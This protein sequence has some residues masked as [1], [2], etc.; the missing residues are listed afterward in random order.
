MANT[1][2]AGLDG[3]TQ[4]RQ[5]LL[6][7]PPR[8]VHGSVAL[9]GLLLLTALA[10]SALTEANLVVRLDG[11]VRPMGSGQVTYSPG[12]D[13]SQGSR[14]PGDGLVVSVP[15]RLGS[16]VR[17]GQV[18][19]QLETEGLDNELDKRRQLIEDGEEEVADLGR[20][21]ALTAQQHTD[22]RAHTAAELALAREEV[23]RTRAQQAEDVRIFKAELG[24]AEDEERRLYPVVRGGSGSMT[25]LVKAQAATA[26]ARA[27]I[28]RAAV[29]VAVGRVD[30]LLAKLEQLDSADAVTRKELGLKRRTRQREVES[31]RRD[32]VNLELQRR[33]T[34]LLAPCDGVVTNIDLGAG[35]VLERGKPV[36]EI[37]QEHGFRFE[38]TVS[39]EEMG[40]LRVGLP[41]R[42]KL[43]AFDH[44]RYGVVTGTVSFIAPDSGTG[45]GQGARYWVRIDL[46]GDA[47]GQGELLGQIKLGMAGQ[48]EIVTERERLLVLLARRLRQ[49]ISLN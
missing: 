3:C 26:E 16:K 28:A 4:F 21:L 29:P 38:G 20:L 32:L 13:G 18:V 17:R 1:R 30:V 23:R 49:S 14:H 2:F 5:T 46:D 6:A 34:S 40:H 42:I 19:V 43:D 22:A 25:E 9:L 35:G 11:R 15:V 47:V 8:L 33:E 31:A 37:A 41:V 12:G 10:W 39:S 45:N 44:Q 48:A 24:A 7:R 36:M 27:K